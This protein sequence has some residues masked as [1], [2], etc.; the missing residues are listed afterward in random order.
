[1]SNL[2][3]MRE[4]LLFVYCKMANETS[5]SSKLSVVGILKSLR[6]ALRVP[7]IASSDHHGI[8]F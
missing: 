1:M 6:E 5:L 8:V 4:V 7:C 2:N 3:Q